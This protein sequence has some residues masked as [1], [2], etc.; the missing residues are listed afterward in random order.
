MMFETYTFKIIANLSSVNELKDEL[1]A[2][3]VS[4]I[5]HHT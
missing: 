2:W 4:D 5:V 3:I 1:N